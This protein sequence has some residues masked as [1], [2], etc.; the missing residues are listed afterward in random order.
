MN[1]TKHRTATGYTRISSTK[2]ATGHEVVALGGVEVDG[3]ESTRGEFSHLSRPAPRARTMPATF[4][5]GFPMELAEL[6]KDC[7]FVA[8]TSPIGTSA[9]TV[10][11]ACFFVCSPF[12]MYCLKSEGFGQ[13]GTTRACLNAGDNYRANL[14]IKRGDET[15]NSE[16]TVYAGRN[17]HRSPIQ[18]DSETRSRR[19]SH[20]LRRRRTQARHRPM[21]SYKGR[22]AKVTRHP[23][24]FN[25]GIRR[26]PFL[27]VM[28][29]IKLKKK[30][31]RGNSSA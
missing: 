29:R 10:K 26:D 12:S 30:R 7:T 17:I 16:D 19:P 5:W 13:N 22:S 14:P 28:L 25:R 6:P 4:T 2:M 24:R 21:V 3:L 8:G 20:L 15:R 27:G 23:R 11:S 1:T 18:S 31:R 9:P